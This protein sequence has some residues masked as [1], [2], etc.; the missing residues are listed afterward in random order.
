MFYRDFRRVCVRFRRLWRV[1]RLPLRFL[2]S[3]DRRRVRLGG[4]CAR[5]MRFLRVRA[6]R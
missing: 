4:W 2:P 5:D 3:C 1:D 6:L